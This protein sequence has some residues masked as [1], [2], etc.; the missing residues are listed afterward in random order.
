MCPSFFV[1]FYFRGQGFTIGLLTMISFIL[2]AITSMLCGYIGM[3]VAVYSNARTTINCMQDG[4]KDGFN[5]AFRAGA[6]IGFALTGIAI[7]VMYAAMCG[8][9]TMYE[10]TEWMIMFVL[11]RLWSRR[12]LH[13]HVRSC[14]RWYLHQGC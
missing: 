3:H 4:F 10:P 14:R 9:A 7:L 8:Y 2:G 1:R 12:F 6:V 13:C 5:T 11:V